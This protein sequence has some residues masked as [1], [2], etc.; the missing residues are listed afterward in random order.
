MKL[1]YTEEEKRERWKLEKAKGKSRF[2]WKYGFL[3]WGLLVLLVTMP[4]LRYYEPDP[5]LFINAV[6]GLFIWSL[7]GFCCGI[8]LWHQRKKKYG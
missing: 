3:R 4:V 6:A 8:F 5:N 2:I 1:H 7:A